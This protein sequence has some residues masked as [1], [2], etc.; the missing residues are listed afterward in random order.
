MTRATI[1]NIN[2]AIAHANVEIVKGAGYFYFMPTENAPDWTIEPES[3]YVTRLS[4][5]TKK[6]WVDHVL[7]D[8]GL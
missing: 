3:V 1:K 5:L 7:G 4:D 8:F 6:Q 2:H